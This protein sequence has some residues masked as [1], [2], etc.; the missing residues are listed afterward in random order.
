MTI[1]RKH[2]YESMTIYEPAGV[3]IQHDSGTRL[4][5]LAR[6][7]QRLGT[8]LSVSNGFYLK[9]LWIYLRIYHSQTTN[10]EQV[11]TNDVF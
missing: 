1:Y 10:I 8:R 4:V 7:N 9:E 3:N 5:S 2:N 6:D 11:C